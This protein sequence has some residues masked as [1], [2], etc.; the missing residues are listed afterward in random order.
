M[1]KN[2]KIFESVI[3]RTKNKEIFNYSSI[4]NTSW[5][6]LIQKAKKFQNI[7][8]DLENDESTGDKRTFYFKKD[9]RENQP[10]KYEINAELY[11]A[12]GDWEYPV[13]YFRIEL[14]KQYSLINN[15][16]KEDP[17]YIWDLETDYSAGLTKN[18]VI[19]P[20]IE[21]G[22]NLKSNMK[23]GLRAYTTEDPEYDKLKS[24][25]KDYSKLWKWLESYLENAIEKRHEIL[26]DKENKEDETKSNS[27]EPIKSI[28]PPVNK[29]SEKDDD[30]NKKD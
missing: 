10:I 7:S 9:L 26:D 28:D 2:F 12:G 14:T 6:K 29:L 17:E 13:Y 5:N 20:P 19:I 4:I 27:D 8:F 30:K 15:K 23:G 24:S 11:E 22:N 18:Y 1:L 3:K 21:S 16:Y 25:K